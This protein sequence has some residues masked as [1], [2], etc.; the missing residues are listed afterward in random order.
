MGKNQESEKCGKGSIDHP[1]SRQRWEVLLV[2]MAM[3][4]TGK[5]RVKVGKGKQRAKGE[6]TKTE[7]KK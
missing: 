6:E 1:S 2:A 5:Q 4:Q 7:G 3:Q